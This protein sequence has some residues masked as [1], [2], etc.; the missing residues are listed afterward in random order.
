MLARHLLPALLL[1]TASLPP[2]A[3]AAIDE[4]QRL[5]DENL[6]LQQQVEQL[7]QQSAASVGEVFAPELSQLAPD[8]AER[9]AERIVAELLVGARA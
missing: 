4:L 9:T 7:R 5:R 8:V 1:V 3:L 2:S 6:R